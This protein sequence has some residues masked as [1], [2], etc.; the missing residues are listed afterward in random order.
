MERKLGTRAQLGS[1]GL[2]DRPS[3]WNTAPRAKLTIPL[4]LI[5]RGPVG[6]NYRRMPDAEHVYVELRLGQRLART[7][8]TAEEDAP[9]QIA[10]VLQLLGFE[11]T[12]T[13]GNWND[14]EDKVYNL[15][16]DA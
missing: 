5:N 15:E 14:D 4:T 16:G 8:L 6:V 1:E 11:P 13:V 2:P 10:D 3:G 7:P 12:V 9:Q